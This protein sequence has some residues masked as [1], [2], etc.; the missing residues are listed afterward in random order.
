MSD[1]P[2][3]TPSTTPSTLRRRSLASRSGYALTIVA[4]LAASAACS[5]AVA[6][7]WARATA[8][9]PGLPPIEASVDGA[10]VAPIAAALAVVCLAA[11]GAVIAT[12]RWVRRAL[13]VLIVGC[14]AVVVFVAVA[15]GSTTG[16]LEDALSAKGWTGGHYDRSVTAWRVVAGFAAALTMAAGAVV[17]RFGGEWATM[18]ARYDSPADT[19][20]ARPTADEE[21][22][23]AAMWRALDDGG[24][25][26]TTT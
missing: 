26:T 12:R 23:D 19:Q 20:S 3:S 14:A 13:G 24:D 18:G 6:Q 17:A 2:T 22:S 21:L 10:D 4:G 7:P 25:P 8:T 11:F 16:L 15:P 9:V 5:V 1:G